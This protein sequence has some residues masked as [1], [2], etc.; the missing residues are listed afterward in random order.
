MLSDIHFKRH[1][2]TLTISN[3]LPV[4]HASQDQGQLILPV[5]PLFHV[6]IVP[7]RILLMIASSDELT[8]AYARIAALWGETRYSKRIRKELSPAL[9]KVKPGR[10]D[11]M[12]NR[13]GTKY[14]TPTATPVGVRR[15]SRKVKCGDG[16]GG[17]LSLR[18]D[19][20]P[21]HE[22]ALS[23]QASVRNTM[24]DEG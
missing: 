17:D 24:A 10:L 13:T 16:D 6:S 12:V 20:P 14:S 8:S 4:L 21:Q 18:H 9:Y 2:G 3:M 5:R 1:P 7:S 15:S 23:K 19:S 22:A 11:R